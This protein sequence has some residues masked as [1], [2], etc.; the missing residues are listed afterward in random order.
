M[1]LVRDSQVV[2]FATQHCTIRSRMSDPGDTLLHQTNLAL[3]VAG[4]HFVRER[5]ALW[6]GSTIRSKGSE[7]WARGGC[8]T[9]P[10]SRLP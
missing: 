5:R 3:S 1:I 9:P 10:Y 4:H 2:T 8:E 7:A 6:F